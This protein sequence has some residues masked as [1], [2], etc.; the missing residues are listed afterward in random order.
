MK[1]RK[2]R[3]SSVVAVSLSVLISAALLSSCTSGSKEDPWDHSAAFS[4]DILIPTDKEEVRFTG[5]E[6]TGESFSRDIEGNF[7]SQSA[8]VRVNTLDYHSVNTVVY[9]SVENALEGAVSYDRTHSAYYQLLTGED[10]VWQLAVYRNEADAE[11]AGVLGEFQKLSYDMSSAPKYEGEDRIYSSSDAYYGGFKDVTLPASWQT[12][13]FDFPIYTNTIYPWA[14]NAYGIETLFAPA[15]PTQF[16]PVGFYRYTFDVDSSWI[17][18]G[19]RVYISFGGVESAYYVYVNGYEVG[20]S[21]DTFD[22][23]DF[24]ITPYLNE[25]GQDNILAVK[26]YRWCD[27]SYYEDQDFLRLAGIFRDV[28][29]Y[30]TTGVRMSD[31]TVVTDLDDDYEDA[32]LKIDVEIDN[33]TLNEVANRELSI[34]VKL[35]DADG[36]Q[37]FYNKPLR[38]SVP[39]V[40]SGEQAIV[41]LERKVNSP[42]LWS[43]EDPYLYTLVISLYDSEGAYYGSISQQLGFREITF[44]PTVGTTENEYY[45]TILL[46]GKPMQL[47]GVNRHENDPE[48]GRYVSREL[49]EADIV[50]M[51]NLNINAVRTSHYPDDEMF[52]NMCDKYGILVLGECN[53]ETHYNIDGTNTELY[54]SELIK[55]RIMA[56]TTAYKNRTCIVIWSMGNETI[57]GT[58]TFINA[59][60]DL[61]Q[62]DPTR[63]IHFESQGSG[64]GV[65]IAST[66]Y[67]TVEDVA[68]RGTW[69][70]H[71]PYLICE[72]AHSMGN[73]TGNLYE[74]WEAIRGADNILGGFIWDYVDQSIKTEIPENKFDYYGDGTY[75]AFGGCWG[76]NPNSGD[77]CQNG[78]I[79]SD[80]RVQPEAIEVK[81]VY[82]SVWF[83]ADDELSADNKTLNVYNEYRFTDLSEFDYRYE[84]LCNGNVVDSGSFEISCAPMEETTVEVPFNMPVEIEPESEYLLTVYACLKE[85]AL[86]ADAGYEIALE[87]FAVECET[88]TISADISSMPDV[89]VADSSTGLTV[90]G[91]NFEIV[92]EKQKGS[93]DSFVYNGETIMD[94]GP[95][96]AYSRGRT[97]NDLDWLA[98]DNAQVSSATS[99]DYEITDGGKSVT[100]NVELK[101]SAA[102]CT[103]DVTYVI[104]G[105]GQVKVTS[106]LNLTDEVTEIYRFGSVMTLPMDYE[107]MTYYG[108]GDADTYVDRKRG[109]PA[110]IYSQS[111]SDSFFPYGNPQDTGNKTE[112]RYIYVTSDEKDTGILITCDGLLE[113]SALHYT[114]KQLT[115]AGRVYELPEI[116]QTYLSVDY[117][118]RGTGGASCGPGPLTQYRLNNDGTDYTYSYTIVPFDKNTDD[119]EE[120]VKLWRDV[121]DAE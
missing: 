15:A 48:T 98:L 25:D 74:Y 27:G 1:K 46:N 34:D 57:A 23:A 60:A 82:Q 99:F 114:A 10:N 41:S 22:A 9:D 35:F 20:Y 19:R 102:N 70:N 81:Y 103:Q 11:A 76:D 69:E 84:L 45:Q 104:Y 53:I 101:I 89:T 29:L 12:Q 55:D 38:K 121:T 32:T 6:W 110:G 97:S 91:E 65:D 100:V 16:N 86:W 8:V 50:Q 52:Y 119:V 24:D 109:S 49:E 3:P 64:G 5:I 43:D 87:Q 59:I 33:T 51:K 68:A 44:D 21:E 118:Q 30:S 42:R 31:Y 106:T 54:F 111:V 93:I 72:Y 61:K 67:S 80:R 2:P 120:L 40:A 63:P 116:T 113:G 92:F 117:G 95:V 79:S 17:S 73:S 77:F 83:T 18:E 7:T 66:M 78:I 62:R 94:Q 58:E 112:L 90:T 85:D 28:Y 96:P 71:M 115:D 14:G 26:V 107:N 88:E 39:A 75:Y 13:G 47:K 108:R 105:D 36:N 37:L 56:H 4:S